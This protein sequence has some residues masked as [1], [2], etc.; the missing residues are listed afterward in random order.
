MNTMFAVSAAAVALE[1]KAQPYIAAALGSRMPAATA[2]VLP[3]AY[4]GVVLVNV[5]AASFA[6]ISLGM[7]VGKARKK[8]NVEVRELGV[9]CEAAFRACALPRAADAP[10]ALA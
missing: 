3:A 9:A 1:A 7:K 8:Y 2:L 5:V 10:C 4:A 6:V